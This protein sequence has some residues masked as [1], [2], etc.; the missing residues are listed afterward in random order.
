MKKVIW[1]LALASGQLVQGYK[2]M[3]LKTGTDVVAL[4]AT[5]AQEIT[6]RSERAQQQAQEDLAQL[7][8]QDPNTRT[9]DSVIR[10]FDVI[11]H[12]F[13]TAV[14]AIAILESLHPDE[15]I[16]AA[17][18]TQVLA[19]ESFAIDQFKNNLEL[20]QVIKGYADA[21]D[22]AA[23]S[24][25][26][27][28]MVHELLKDFKRAG[29]DLAPAQ[30]QKVKKLR[31]EIAEISMQ[32]AK[33]IADGQRSIV[34]TSDELAGMDEHFLE[35]LPKTEAGGYTLATDYPTYFGVMQNCSVEATRKKLYLAFNT[36]AYPENIVILNDLIAK[37][38]ELAQL[39]G[40]AHYAAYD[41]ANEMAQ[42]VDRV[43]GFLDGI[44]Q[45]AMVKYEQEVAHFTKHLPEGMTLTDDGKVKPWD[46][47]YLVAQHKKKHYEIDERAIAE[48]FPM[49]KTVHG[50]ISIFEK[51]MSIV[52]KPVEVTG[53]WHEDAQMLAIY[54]GT[55]RLRGYLI[56]DL[57]PRPNKFSHAASS[58]IV[59][60]IMTP[61]GPTVAVDVVMANFPK[62][63]KTRPALLKHD[64][65]VTFFHEFGHAIHTIL[66]ST[67]FAYFSGT[68]TKTDFVELPS[69]MLEEW[70]WDADIVR[71]LSS[72]YKTGEP[73]PK[74]LLAQKIKLKNFDSAHQVL[75]QLFFANFSL[76]C[77]IEGERKD[78]IAID[79]KL[80]EQLRPAL[81]YEPGSYF[82]A[83]F[84]HLTDYG[85]KYYGYMWSK[86][87]ALDLFAEIKKHGLLNPAIGIQ[88]V[89]KIL[90]KGGSKD[91]NEM[92]VDFL[93]REPNQEAF[94]KDHGF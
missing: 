63:T 94:Y 67:E 86:V 48:Y 3:E 34:V 89:N 7:I 10:A 55:T 6:E 75:R 74:E 35:Q 87:F 73:M 22:L 50:L 90:A 8:A 59:S 65:V 78:L 66:G 23:L 28:Y 32:F 16:R 24:E 70:M 71:D 40:F 51:F 79:K 46:Q 38:D 1:V 61:Q 17:A 69:Q 45:R 4:F 84:G 19:L 68:A 25:Q 31:K 43:R 27:R 85:A 9:F 88:Y 92:L 39:L 81:A 5:T 57:H 15:A 29:L 42:S 13:A 52:I 49:E 44:A 33:N 37:R 76:G 60:T 36:R 20:Y 58:T 64:D 14:S 12:R 62:S 80:A 91:P 93:G 18:H 30:L 82:Y 11:G 26:Q 56:L 47:N 2:S 53:L 77:F 21:A 54:D 72:H 41:I 83:S